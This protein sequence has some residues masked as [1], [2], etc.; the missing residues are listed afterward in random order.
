MIYWSYV[1]LIFL[2]NFLHNRIIPCLPT[3]LAILLNSAID[4]LSVRMDVHSLHLGWIRFRPNTGSMLC[5][6]NEGSFL[7]FYYK[8]NLDIYRSLLFCFHN[9]GVRLPL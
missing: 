5:T 3:T 4:R 2:P 1:S 6:S 8:N 9:F 7:K